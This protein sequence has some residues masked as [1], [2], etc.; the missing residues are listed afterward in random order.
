V[1]V[2]EIWERILIRSGQFILNR[3]KIE[4]D[5][6]KF[7]VL[8]EDALAEYNQSRPFDKTYNITIPTRNFTFTDSFDPDLGIIPSMLAEVT[9]TR[10]YNANPFLYGTGFGSPLYNNSELIE[11]LQVPWDYTAPKLTVPMNGDFKIIAIYPHRVVK[12][13][14]TL[15]DIHWKVSTISVNNDQHFFKLL[16]GLFLQG[17]GRSRRSFTLSDIPITMD[18]DQLYS[19]GKEIEE[20]ALEDIHKNKK[21]YLAMR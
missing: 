11:P 8:V 12:D 9:P 21:I 19:E 1:R 6:E 16:Q 4:L 13:V 18:A 14:S 5:P 10:A 2:D 17:I 7:V 20:R 3:N 15:S